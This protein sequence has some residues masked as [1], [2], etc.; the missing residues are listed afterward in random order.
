MKL[1][2]PVAKPATRV[3]HHVDM[4]IQTTGERDEH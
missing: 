1:D 3:R 2:A 4:A